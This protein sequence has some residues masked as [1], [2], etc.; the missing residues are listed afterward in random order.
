M[1][2][3]FLTIDFRFCVYILNLWDFRPGWFEDTQQQMGFKTTVATSWAQ[4]Q[5]MYLFWE[6]PNPTFL[7]KNKSVKINCNY[8]KVSFLVRSYL[9]YWAV[10][11]VLPAALHLTFYCSFFFIPSCPENEHNFVYP[12]VN[13]FVLHQRCKY[14]QKQGLLSWFFFKS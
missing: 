1:K 3:C 10:G 9:P 14:N 6:E 11:G 4:P 5:L 8:N 12:F 13:L 2:L 7:T